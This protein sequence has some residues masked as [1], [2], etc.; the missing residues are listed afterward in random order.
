MKIYEKKKKFVEYDDKKLYVLN[1]VDSDNLNEYSEFPIGST[2]KLFTIISLLLLHQNKQININSIIGKNI[3]DSQITNLKIIDIM[4]HTSGLKNMYDNIEYGY[5]NKKYNSATE[6]YNDSYVANEKLINTQPGTYIY[7]NIGYQILGVLIEKI[8]NMSY[9]D[10][11][12]ENILI[13]LKMNNT[14]VQDCNITL[15][16]VKIKKLTKFQKWE[17]TFASSAGELKSCVHDLIKFSN[18]FKLLNKDSIEIL[19]KLYIFRE[20]KTDNTFKISHTG[21]ISGGKS[22]L[23]FIF[24]KNF[25][26]KNIYIHLETGV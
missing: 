25:I 12:K 3:D 8:S 9:S 24:N 15:Y 7:S 11:V 10:F 1:N 21:G 14:G 22:K 20:N 26:I 23:V 13:P 19:K 4:N 5:S 16:D 18:V 17:R 6:V 2:T